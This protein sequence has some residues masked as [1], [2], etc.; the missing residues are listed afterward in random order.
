MRTF[1]TIAGSPYQCGLALGQLQ[2]RALR[3]RIASTLDHRRQS[4]V[5]S[6]AITSRARELVATIR[7]VAPEWLAE[8]KGTADGAG[9]EVDDILMLNCLPTDFYPPSDGDC[10]GFIEIGPQRNRLFKI[11]DNRNHVQCLAVQS[12][13]DHPTLQFGRDI[14][15]LGMAHVLNRHGLA[16]ANHTG[17]TTDRVSDAPRLNDC[18]MLR[19]IVERATSVDQVPAVFEELLQHSAAG[20]AAK[21]RG[22]IL[23]FADSERGLLLESIE[24]D[25]A[26][27][28]VDQG[29]TAVSNHF[30]APKAQAWENAP[31][32]R[33]TRRRLQRMQELLDAHTPAPAD[34]DVFAISRDRKDR[35]D[36]LCNDDTEHFWMTVSAQLHVIP[37]HQPDRAVTYACCGNTRHSLYVPVPIGTAESFVPLANGDFYAA[38]DRLYRTHR[39]SRHLQPT[40]AAFEHDQAG[41]RNPR[42][43]WPEAYDLL[44]RALEDA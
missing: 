44:L 25:Y 36:S 42:Q 17:S 20:G 21:G 1:T 26:A 29:L 2:R 40:Q 5:T 9:V 18:H 30:L 43:T 33:N 14:G 3:D 10:T 4:G 13:D 23:L 35:P 32:N 34:R 22:A 24:D 12:T 39:C 37:R 28:F 11:R 6:S 27:T 8:A 31:P 19:F 38:T 41:H 16:G 15:N 7:N